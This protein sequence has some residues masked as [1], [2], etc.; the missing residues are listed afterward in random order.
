MKQDLDSTK[1]QGGHAKQ[2]PVEQ[3]ELLEEAKISE[4]LPGIADQRFEAS[5]VVARDGWFYVIFDNSTNIG[6]IKDG[7][8]AT[9][10]NHLIEQNQGAAAGYEDIAYDPITNRFYLLI[11]V[12]PH[13]GNLVAKVEEYDEQFRYISSGWLDFPLDHPNKGLEG[14]TCIHQAGQT[15]LLGICEGN[16][17][18]G[19]AAGR[20]PG[21]GRIQI[22]R[23]DQDR[24]DHMGTMKLPKSLWFE[25][26]SCLAVVDDRIAVVSQ[27]SSAAW[28]G[29]FSP[30]S[31][32]VVDEGSV[33]RFPLDDKGKVLYCN[34]EGISR[35]DAARFV[36]VSDK[37]KVKEQSKRCCAKEMSIHVFK[38][39][40]HRENQ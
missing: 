22:F 17:C 7:L 19:G 20:K 25:D 9:E 18:R 29:R 31:W 24:W 2:P 16:K 26:Y 8:R 10:G 30:S 6:C 39:P 13:F 27:A 3:L 4:L 33:Y 36:V 32:E 40:R 28:I 14:L 15:Y 5:G 21:G 12:L 1:Y 37:A 38:T 35:V 34:I 11:E 23:K